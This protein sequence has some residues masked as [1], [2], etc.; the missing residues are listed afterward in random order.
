MTH[1]PNIIN[2]IATKFTAKTT[3]DNEGEPDYEAI[4][5][6]MQLLYD[7]TVTLH[8]PQIGENHRHICSTMKPT[9]YTTLS[10]TTWK[11][12]PTQYHTIRF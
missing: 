3:P 6:I 7:N 5:K 2:E 8:M 12:L 11:N 1:K 4:G 9:L 10:T